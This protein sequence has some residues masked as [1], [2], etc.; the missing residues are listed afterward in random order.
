MCQEH[1]MMTQ[2]PFPLCTM[3]RSPPQLPCKSSHQLVSHLIRAKTHLSG[4]G[5]LG[6]QDLSTGYPLGGRGYLI[7]FL[8]SLELAKNKGQLVSQ[9]GWLLHTA[10]EVLFTKQRR[11]WMSS[12]WPRQWSGCVSQ[13]WCNL[14]RGGPVADSHSSGNRQHLS[15]PGTV[16]GW[17]EVSILPVEI[18]VVTG[19]RELDWVTKWVVSGGLSPE[20]SRP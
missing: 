19:E 9:H 15:V 14:V 2:A 12:G 7:F 8:K 6:A 13:V 16:P 18:C 4:Q 17:S 1:L 3:G 5:K 11:C 20:K 10:A